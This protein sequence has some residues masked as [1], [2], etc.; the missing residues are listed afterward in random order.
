LSRDK[1]SGNGDPPSAERATQ[2]N[3]GLFGGLRGRQTSVDAGSLSHICNTLA[4][5]DTTLQSSAQDCYY[6]L[7]EGHFI[8]EDSGS[9]H[10]EHSEQTSRKSVMTKVDS[11]VAIGTFSDILAWVKKS[12]DPKGDSNSFSRVTAPNDRGM[13]T[14]TSGCVNSSTKAAS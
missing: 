3:T 10:A 1:A 8:N 5:Q 4:P 9:V 7:T 11:A 13:P 12:P 14:M 6:G 2:A